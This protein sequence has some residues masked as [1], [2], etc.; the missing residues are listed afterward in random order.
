MGG[1][2]GLRYTHT[3]ELRSRAPLHTSHPHK[4]H[5]RSSPPRHRGAQ[6]AALR[7]LLPHLEAREVA[8]Q[9]VVWG[10]FP[11]LGWPV[12]ALKVPSLEKPCRTGNLCP[13]HRA[14]LV[15]PLCPQAGPQTAKVPALSP[16]ASQCCPPATPGAREATRP[17]PAGA[18]E[19]RSQSLN[20]MSMSGARG[21]PFCP[22]G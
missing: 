12:L 13:G 18:G 14:R 9:V 15:T 8:R 16:A 6:Q 4:R 22:G 21:C 10:L 1:E 17:L 2:A 11:F 7:V 20:D 5:L 19:T 3:A